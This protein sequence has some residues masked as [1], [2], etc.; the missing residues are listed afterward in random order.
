M[1]MQEP[2]VMEL[3]LFDRRALLHQIRKLGSTDAILAIVSSALKLLRKSTSLPKVMSIEIVLSPSRIRHQSAHKVKA[4]SYI[5]V[6]MM[7]L[8]SL[9]NLHLTSISEQKPPVHPKSSIQ[10]GK[11]PPPLHPTIQTCLHHPI[12]RT[13]AMHATPHSTLPSFSYSTTKASTTSNAPTAPHILIPAPTSSPTLKPSIPFPVPA[14]NSSHRK[15]PSRATDMPNIISNVPNARS[16]SKT[17]HISCFI[18]RS[19]MNS[20]VANVLPCWRPPRG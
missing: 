7:V 13:A 14:H 6:M 15:S 9:P 3:R 11:H 8:S 5:L 18:C 2:R 10:F 1:S 20:N 16:N 4:N 17:L 19:D 12:F